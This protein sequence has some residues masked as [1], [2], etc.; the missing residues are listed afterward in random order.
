MGKRVS[1]PTIK[2]R[3][4]KQAVGLLLLSAAVIIG[5]FY[6][7][8]TIDGITYNSYLGHRV[9]KVDDDLEKAVVRPGTRKIDK[10]VQCPSSHIGHAL[11]PFKGSRRL[12][13]PSH[14]G[15]RAQE[16]RATPMSRQE[17]TAWKHHKAPMPL[18]FPAVWRKNSTK[19]TP[20]S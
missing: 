12:L 16:P 3:G 7:P 4:L 14:R 19:V 8:V 20:K 5:I 15:D 10:A 1:A 13:S 11:S 17:T 9:L 6:V 18:L 2:V